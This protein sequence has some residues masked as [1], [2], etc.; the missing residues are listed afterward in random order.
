M[1]CLHKTWFWQAFHYNNIINNNKNNTNIIAS[2][3]YLVLKFHTIEK[4]LSLFLYSTH[5]ILSIF[6]KMCFVYKISIFAFSVYRVSYPFYGVLFDF[7][8]RTPGNS[9]RQ[10]IVYRLQLFI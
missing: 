1:F 3:S 6:Y 7:F 2:N 5:F 8:L 10:N 9:Q 4:R